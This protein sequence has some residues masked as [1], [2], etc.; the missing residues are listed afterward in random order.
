MLATYAQAACFALP[1]RAEAFPISIL[2]AAAFGLPVVASR[3][4]GIPEIISSEAFGFLVEPD[5]EEELAAALARLMADP[6]LRRRL[7][8]GL[9]SFVSTEFTW[10][11]AAES[12]ALL[13]LHSNPDLAKGT[14]R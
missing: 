9:R 12:Y 10:R 5:N 1:S 14:G 13:A 11:K 7:G 6:Q 8:D 4:G 2:E 3:V